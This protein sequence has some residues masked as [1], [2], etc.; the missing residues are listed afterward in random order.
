MFGTKSPCAVL[1]A[2]RTVVTSSKLPYALMSA[3][4]TSSFSCTGTL[5]TVTLIRLVP[6]Y[7]GWSRKCFVETLLLASFT[8]S[9]SE[10]NRSSKVAKLRRQKYRHGMHADFKSSS[11]ISRLIPANLL[12]IKTVMMLDKVFGSTSA[13]SSGMGSISV[14]LK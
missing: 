4:R 7:S 14:P 3:T 13:T 2:D 9:S 12:V 10:G 6:L 8:V 11:N 1:S 5:L